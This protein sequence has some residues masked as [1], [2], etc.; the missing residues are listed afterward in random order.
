MLPKRNSNCITDDAIQNFEV[1]GRD[2]ERLGTLQLIWAH[3]VSSLEHFVESN[4]VQSFESTI[5]IQQRQVG[6]ET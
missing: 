6:H 2:D 3:L 1:P 4:R 5:A